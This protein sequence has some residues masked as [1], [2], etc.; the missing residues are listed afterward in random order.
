VTLNTAFER[1]HH[2][3]IETKTLDGHLKAVETYFA[4]V[5]DLLKA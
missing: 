1:M 3:P 4:T 2:Q 5:R